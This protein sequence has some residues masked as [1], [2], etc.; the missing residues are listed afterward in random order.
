MS[1]RSEILDLVAR[2]E[3]EVRLPRIRRVFMPEPDPSP[4]NDAEFGLIELTD[5]SVGLYYAWLGDSQKGM[6]ERFSAAAFAGRDVVEVAR[7]YGNDDDAER[8]LGLAA[9]NAITQS[10]FTRAGLTLDAAANSMG[11]LS[12]QPGD[13]LGMIGKFPSLVRRAEQQGTRVTVVERK[14]HMVKEEGLIR[15]TL[16]PA[17]LYDC[18]KVI[19]TAAT[20]LNNSLDDMLPFCTHA[21]KLVVIG[22]TAGFFPDPLFE[23]GVNLVGGTHVIDPRQAVR[24][25]QQRMN[26]GPSA[27]R[28]SLSKVDYPGFDEILRRIRE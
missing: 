18:N 14:A 1:I 27:R 15:V 25:L 3:D 6:N 28:F 26:L 12:L 11:E 4:D 22:P 8:S 9:I 21:E 7:L 19:S 10:V 2:A 5:G 24:R 16:D 23:R 13:H 17:A 20:M